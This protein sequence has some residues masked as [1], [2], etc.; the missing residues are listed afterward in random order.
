MMTR[1]A[2]ARLYEEVLESAGFSRNR[3][4]E[5]TETL[6]Q[7][8]TNAVEESSD[9]ISFQ[10]GR[11]AAYHQRKALQLGRFH[12]QCPDRSHNHQDSD[13]NP[14]S[15]PVNGPNPSE[16]WERGQLVE[17]TAVEDTQGGAS[18]SDHE[19]VL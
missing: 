3:R 17:P 1:E 4:Q 11:S 6:D 10:S 19:G 16:M 2:V 15:S 8:G 7:V 18:A 9:S 14:V 12:N 13:S 5:P